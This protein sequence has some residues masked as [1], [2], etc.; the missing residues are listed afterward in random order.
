[1]PRLREIS[2]CLFRRWFGWPCPSG[3]PGAST[4]AWPTLTAA[5]T[6]SFRESWFT[7]QG[8]RVKTTLQCFLQLAFSQQNGRLSA[9]MR[10]LARMHLR[11]HLCGMERHSTQSLLFRLLLRLRLRLR[12]FSRSVGFSPAN[13]SCAL[14]RQSK[15]AIRSFDSSLLDWPK[16]PDR[17]TFYCTAVV[18]NWYETPIILNPS[19]S[20]PCKPE[21]CSA[22]RLHLLVPHP[23]VPP[24]SVPGTMWISGVQ[25]RVLVLQD[26]VRGC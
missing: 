21:L 17:Y 3:A 22:T 6:G 7:V 25:A 16:L 24:P 20:K 26:Q 2:F 1:M 4:P 19:P 5:C 11:A 18:I 8:L 23:L 12:R 13:Q 10:A 15:Q 9:R 14:P